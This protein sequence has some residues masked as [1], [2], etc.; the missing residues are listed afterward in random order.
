MSRI[1][2]NSDEV[3][4]TKSEGNLVDVQF[5][6]GEKLEGL[7]PRRLFPVTGLRRYIT[8]LDEEGVEKAVIRN[9]D[10][11]IPESRDVILS[12]LDEYYL[13][14]KI[15]KLLD[16]REK[17]GIL[18]WKVETDRGIKEFDIRNRHHDIK[19]LY[20][21]RVLVRDSDDNRYEIPD[22]NK[23]DKKSYKLLIAEI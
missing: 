3:M 9:V 23:L 13:I 8:L 10:D 17:Y 14:P 12:C 1:Y 15:T 22:Y 4:I 21:G 11:L 5:Y 16:S 19:T 18:K 6:T 2:I 20:D 7:E